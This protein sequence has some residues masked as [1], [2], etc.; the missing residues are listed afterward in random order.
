VTPFLTL[1]DCNEAM[2]D[3]RGHWPVPGEVSAFFILL[4]SIAMW[5]L[6]NLYHSINLDRRMATPAVSMLSARWLK[7]YP[8]I[9]TGVP[10]ASTFKM[11]ATECY[12]HADTSRRIRFDSPG[13]ADSS[14][15]LPDSG[16]HLPPELAALF[17]LL[18]SIAMRTLRK[19]YHLIP[20]AERNSTHSVL[21]LSEHWVKG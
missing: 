1:A 7:G 10:L 12:K 11:L 16:R 4:T 15:T 13:R 2:H 20:L 21:T 14:E 18:T 17:I 5:I 6:R 19:L 3:S 9:C 8:N